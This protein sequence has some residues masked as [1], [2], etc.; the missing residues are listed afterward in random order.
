MEKPFLNGMKVKTTEHYYKQNK[1][2]VS[3]V[4]VLPEGVTPH[5][6]ATPVRWLKQ[7]GKIIKE[8]QNQVVIMVSTDLEKVNNLN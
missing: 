6:I 8:Q 1:R 4:V 3:G 2:R 7:E 5:P